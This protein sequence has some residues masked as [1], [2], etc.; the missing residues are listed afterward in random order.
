MLRDEVVDAV[1]DGTFHIYPVSTID[2]GIAILT[3]V[4]A[5]EPDDAGNYPQGTLNFAVQA[6][7]KELAEKVKSYSFLSNGDRE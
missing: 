4:E 1:R 5:G 6:R 3:G 7:L 2:E